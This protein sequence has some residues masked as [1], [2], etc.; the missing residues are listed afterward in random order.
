VTSTGLYR[1]FFTFL[2]IATV[3]GPG[4]AHGDDLLTGAGLLEALRAG[5]HNIYF[6]HAQTDWS[7]DD[8]IDKPG[9]WNSCDPGRVRQLSSH[10]RRVA[11]EVGT[12]MRALRIPVGKVLSSPY[13]RCVET[14]RLIARAPVTT[15]TDIMNLRVAEYFD[16]RDAIVKRARARLATLPAAGTNTV[17]VAHGN[18]AR[19]ATPVYPDEAE[20]VIFRPVQ[21]ADFV[22]VG[23]LKPGQWAEL[24]S[25]G[26]SGQIPQSASDNATQLNTT[27]Q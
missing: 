25:P 5:G 13:C 22:L 10:G 8:H 9:D 17:L 18:V 2:I 16:G 12:A 20:A 11:S 14:A 6:R 27:N 4:Q 23:R 3:A 7:Q 19:E 15:T 21:N 24:L 26:A 1:H